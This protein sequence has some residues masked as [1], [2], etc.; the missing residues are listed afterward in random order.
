MN[1]VIFGLIL[2]VCVLGMALMLLNER[3]GRK[4]EPPQPPAST[5]IAEN[6]PEYRQPA[7]GMLAPSDTATPPAPMVAP[8]APALEEP[9]P[10]P[11][12]AARLEREDAEAALAPPQR[13]QEIAPVEEKTEAVVPVV[14]P[15][16]SPAPQKSV[17]ETVP[18]TAAPVRK[19]EARVEAKPEA[20]P[21]AKSEKGSPVAKTINRFVI[22]SR[23]KGA[24][25]R[26]A[27]NAPLNYKS[28]TLENPDRVVIDLDGAWQFP[29]NPGI[30]KNELVQSVRVGKNG[31]KTR[32]VIDLKEKP[33]SARVLPAKGG[34]GF[35][36][37]VDK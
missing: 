1:K 11:I 5:A 23:E 29:A 34:D 28:M 24:T 15:P 7:T 35:D 21:E 32:V 27:A 19:K 10:T 4:T 36:V 2:A 33:R 17:V 26:I 22:F 18:D 16:A 30:P 3:L 13:P 8:A 9:A 37:R 6:R 31:D 12:E 25:I 14:A 20:K